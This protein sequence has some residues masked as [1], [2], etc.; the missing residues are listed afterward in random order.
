[1][2]TE[3]E[4]AALHLA[5]ST[6]GLG[7]PDQIHSWQGSGG[8]SNIQLQPGTYRVSGSA[9]FTVQAIIARNVEGEPVWETSDAAGP[10]RSPAREILGEPL[11]TDPLTLTTPTE[12][13]VTRG[14]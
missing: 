6:K 5:R 12:V 11:S 3:A 4:E 8:W 9:A 7:H 14:P 13:R 1:M 2:T 10:T